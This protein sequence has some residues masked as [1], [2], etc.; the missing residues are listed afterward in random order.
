MPGTNNHAD[1][2]APAR[3][4]RTGSRSRGGA[5]APLSGRGGR[6]TSIGG[7]GMA[8]GGGSAG[9]AWIV[10]LIAVGFAIWLQNRWMKRE[11]ERALAG[12][13]TVANGFADKA[14]DWMLRKRGLAPE[15]VASG[16]SAANAFD[17]SDRRIDC[18]ACGGL[19]AAYG[20]DGKPR[21]CGICQGVG[22]RMIRPFDAQDVVCSACG[23]MGRIETEDGAAETCPR[24]D[25]RG[26]VRPAP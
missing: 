20:D 15:K 13:R 16:G 26:F 24:C 25:G 3:L 8:R 1:A 10:V 17:R 5:V 6:R 21:P 23:G 7:G 19:G 11:K 14:A 18:V 4:R 12:E 22:Y 9:Y 2:G